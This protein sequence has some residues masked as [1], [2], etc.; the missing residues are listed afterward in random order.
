MDFPTYQFVLHFT[1][2]KILELV[3]NTVKKYLEVHL[4]GSPKVRQ[5]LQ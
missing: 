1:S 3:L 5:D 4:Y 2:S